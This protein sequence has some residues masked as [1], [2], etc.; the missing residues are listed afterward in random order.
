MPTITFSLK[1]FT[2]LLGK[3]I[4][5]QEFKELLEYAKAE[6][7][8]TNGD[9]VSVK[10]NDTNQPYLWSAEG[11][12]TL[13][14]GVIG[15]EKG[16]PKLNIKKSNKK[17]IVDESV[18]SVRPHIA[19]FIAQGPALNEYILNQLI[20]LQEKI[21]DNYGKKREKIAVGI[22]PTTNI[23][24]PVTYKAVKPESVKFVPLGWHDEQTLA[25]ILL[26]HQKGKEYGKLLEKATNYPILIDTKNEILSFPPIINSDTMGNLKPGDTN[27]FFET[28]GT[29]ER[30]TDLAAIIF[31]HALSMRGYTI[32]SVT[33]TEGKK[34]IE[35][36]QTKT[37]TTKINKQDIKKLLGI[38]LKDAETKKL[39]EK[40]RYNIKGQTV[41]VP[42]YRQDIMHQ[43]DIIE[44]IA[45]MHGYNNIPSATITTF[46]RG[47]TTQN[48]ALI[49][50]CRQLLTGQGYQEIFS[51]IL[52]NKKILQEN[53]RTKEQ[54]IEIENHTSQT[55][56]A[57]RTNIL[58]TLLEFLTNNKHVDYPQKI[59]EQGLTTKRNGNII[60]DQE[61][62]AIAISHPTT[63]FTEI[64][65][66]IT[67]LLNNLGM[68]DFEIKETEHQSYIQGR[69]VNIFVNNENIGT[70]GEIHPEVLSNFGIEMPV[71]A[72]EINMDKLQQA[73]K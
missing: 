7:E 17:I 67:A 72:G 55:Y 20:Q 23:T 27:I 54:L 29:D 42:S 36:P 69:A 33:I 62:L 48:T 47:A 46:T 39:L 49:N 12:A 6:L 43:V 24:F 10:F 50:T 9:N 38:E 30:A 35:T 28:T 13:L 73:K 66:T 21:C 14:R 65:Q 68:H 1:D 59:F 44:D 8:Q 19:A 56:S 2:T 34:S 37:T 4:N 41:E 5:I 52:S 15:K 53:M 31:A 63:N 11:I 61:L 64:R 18:N 16:I 60:T 26:S 32:L 25:Q 45:I 40:A 58:P 22:Y 51:A 3:K 71:A 57:I 70:F